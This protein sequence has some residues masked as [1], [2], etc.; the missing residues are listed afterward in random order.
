MAL[1][2]KKDA[3]FSGEHCRVLAGAAGIF[4]SFAGLFLV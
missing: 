3:V 1:S 2:T 4:I